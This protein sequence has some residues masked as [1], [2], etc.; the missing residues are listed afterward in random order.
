[1]CFFSLEN[2]TLQLIVHRLWSRSRCTTLKNSKL[3]V[4]QNALQYR[5]DYPK[6]FELQIIE[7]RKIGFFM[8]I[9][10]ISELKYDL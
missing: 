4:T 1:M 10:L 9:F 2:L 3:K 5:L 7:S 6:V 8:I